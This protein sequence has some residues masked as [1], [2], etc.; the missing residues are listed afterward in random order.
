MIILRVEEPK[1]VL[2]KNASRDKPSRTGKEH[3]KLK[4]SVGNI[5]TTCFKLKT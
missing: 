1:G 2:K 5:V 4:A 3:Q